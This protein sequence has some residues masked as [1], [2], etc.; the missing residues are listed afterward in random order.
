MRNVRLCARKSGLSKL[1][2]RVPVPRQATVTI[3]HNFF[4]YYQINDTFPTRLGCVL[5]KLAQSKLSPSSDLF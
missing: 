4:F 5:M 3:S 1:N 2:C